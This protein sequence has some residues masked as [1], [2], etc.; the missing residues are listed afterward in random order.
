M[1]Q[2][3]GATSNKGVLVTGAGTGLG[4]EIALEFARQGANVV[5]HYSHS[6]EGA[7]SAVEEAR[8]GGVRAESMQ[9]DLGE[10]ADVERLGDE[11]ERFL[12]RVDVLVNNAGIT[13][14][15]PILK[16][17]PAHYQKIYDVN[18]RAGFFLTQRF[19]PGMV[20]AGDGAVCNITS[21][22]GLQGAS[23]HAVYAGTKG[24]IIA[25]TRALGVELAHKGVRV[26]AIAPGCFP[27]ENYA[28]A[29]P[30]YTE[31]A[32]K[33]AAAAAIPAGRYGYPIEVA[34]LAV[35]LCSDAASFIVG[36]TLTIDGG[37]TALM[38]L[39]PDFRGESPARFGARYL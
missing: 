27:V 35:F 32:V 26:N 9:A 7:R 11:A 22:H 39:A 4:R 25:Q 5:F 10:L 37:T 8:S 2:L 20:A 34:R 19:V 12:G 24:A 6:S 16:V 14:N 30:G 28:R 36:Q 31:E 21:I 33:K 18:V 23:E 15:K 1:K 13:Y 17:E 3:E 29:I 38:S